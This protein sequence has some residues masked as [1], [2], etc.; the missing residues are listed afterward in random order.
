MSLGDV[1]KAA[2]DLDRNLNAQISA[3]LRKI[4]VL[5]V[6]NNDLSDKNET[7]ENDLQSMTKILREMK[8]K[9][10]HLESVSIDPSGRVARLEE[11][12]RTLLARI[13]ELETTNGK[14]LARATSGSSSSSSVPRQPANLVEQ[15]LSR[16]K[17][18]VLPLVSVDRGASVEAATQRKRQFE[19]VA[20]E[21]DMGRSMVLPYSS[22]YKMPVDVFIFSGSVLY[23]SLRVHMGHIAQYAQ[24][25]MKVKDARALPSEPSAS[26][27][28]VVLFSSSPRPVATISQ[29]LMQRIM[30][31]HNNTR[32]LV[33]R[34]PPYGLLD[35]E[36]HNDLVTVAEV[37]SDRKLR[38]AES[39]YTV[40]LSGLAKK[41]IS[42]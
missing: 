33:L 8:A 4:D 28:L 38:D 27:A 24:L 41:L 17:G 10:L 12:Q 29:E 23:D 1:I 19:Q 42:K 5:A 30:R 37:E 22:H 3:H 15:T 14:L 18:T 7:L 25:E 35:V 34:P 9:I 6:K 11:K 36:S 20:G 32:I 16:G 13:G 21:Q 31:D 40:I 26:R 2:E 39:Y